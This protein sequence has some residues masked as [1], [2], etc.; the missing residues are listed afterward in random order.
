MLDNIYQKGMKAREVMEILERLPNGH[1][2]I[3]LKKAA[4]QQKEKLLFMQGCQL[5]SK[6]MIWLIKSKWQ[7]ISA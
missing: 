5:P 3:F 1:I 7:K 2:N 6:S 4:N